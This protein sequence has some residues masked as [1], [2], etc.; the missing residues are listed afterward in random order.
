M[1]A[2]CA[3][4]GFFFYLQG[5]WKPTSYTAF[6]VTPKRGVIKR[7]LFVFDHRGGAIEEETREIIR[8][9]IGSILHELN[10]QSAGEEGQAAMFE[11]AVLKHLSPEELEKLAD[12][13]KLVFP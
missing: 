12:A 7:F 13:Q 5:I 1:A 4:D 8:G 11:N 6:V 9:A 2:E 10:W 3:E